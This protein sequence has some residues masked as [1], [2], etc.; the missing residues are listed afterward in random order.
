[1]SAARIF[2]RRAIGVILSGT[3]DDGSAGRASI[4]QAGGCT[5]VQNPDDA[6]YTEMPRNALAA[7]EPDYVL[8]AAKIGSKLNQLVGSNGG[9]GKSR[10]KSAR[11]G[12]RMNHNQHDWANPELLPPGEISTLTCPECGGTL[13]ELHEGK[14][15]RFLCHTGHEFSSANL[16]EAQHTVVENAMWVALRALKERAML[17]KKLASGAR[18]ARHSHSEK[19]YRTEEREVRAQADTIQMA[20]FPP[21]SRQVPDISKAKKKRA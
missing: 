17:L 2:G 9:R 18:R 3:L 15:L 16:G 8:A 19:R 14:V 6:T 1:M 13:W 20:L 10:M 21:P 7:V 12:K 5:I 4:Q 11:K